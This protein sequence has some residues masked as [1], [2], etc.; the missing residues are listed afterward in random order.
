MTILPKGRMKPPEYECDLC[1]DRPKFYT[2]E[3]LKRHMSNH[4]PGLSKR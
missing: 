4:F 2:H 1:P 3:G